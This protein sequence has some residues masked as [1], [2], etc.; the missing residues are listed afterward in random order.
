MLRGWV[1]RRSTVVFMVPWVCNFR[2]AVGAFHSFILQIDLI[3]FPCAGT[4]FSK[5]ARTFVMFDANPRIGNIL[6]FYCMYIFNRLE[7]FYCCLVIFFYQCN[8]LTCPCQLCHTLHHRFI[9]DWSF[10]TFSFPNLIDL[11]PNPEPDY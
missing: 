3:F 10:T 2:V 5:N 8:M 6:S 1:W 11:E 9:L 7:W 4:L